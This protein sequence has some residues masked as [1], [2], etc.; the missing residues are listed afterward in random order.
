MPVA[1][2]PLIV[3]RVT[4]ARAVLDQQAI[5][6]IA[7][8]RRVCDPHAGSGGHADACTREVGDEAVLDRETGASNHVDAACAAHAR[9]GNDYQI[10]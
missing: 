7:S 4:E 6:T 8:N 3:A 10:A 9:L 1:E 5:N 2:L